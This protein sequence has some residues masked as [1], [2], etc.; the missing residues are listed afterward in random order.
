MLD[1]WST[2][3]ALDNLKS[4]VVLTQCMT[5]T[6][7]HKINGPNGTPYQKLKYGIGE[8]EMTFDLDPGCRAI[9]CYVMMIGYIDSALK[10]L[11]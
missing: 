8:L 7:N 10:S 1:D 6:L 11:T 9:I 2:Y 4:P 3:I 5:L